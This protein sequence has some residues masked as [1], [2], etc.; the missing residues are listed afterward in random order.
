[1]SRF[2]GDFS[3]KADVKSRIVLPM[4]FKLVLENLGES[5]L[6]V[7]KD[8]FEKCLLIY[9]YSE[10]ERIMDDLRDRINPYDREHTR[11]LRE[12]QRYTAELQLDGNGRILIPKRLMQSIEAEKDV[13]FLG[14][15]KHIE[16]WNSTEY[17]QQAISNDSLEALTEKLLGTPRP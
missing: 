14:V 1:M 5:R 12:Y 10:W 13:T 8:I 15:N 9:P 3:S 7:K 16:L 2:I 4:A 11:F 17:E 6:I